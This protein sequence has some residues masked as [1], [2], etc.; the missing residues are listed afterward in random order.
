MVEEFAGDFFPDAGIDGLGAGEFF[1]AFEHFVAE[2]FVGFGAAGETDDDGVFVE[3]AVA[4]EVVD[5]GE[6]FALG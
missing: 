1:D 3:Q 2:L 6:E 5:G 4:G